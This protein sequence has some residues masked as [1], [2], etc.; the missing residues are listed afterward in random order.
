MTDTAQNATARVH[1]RVTGRVQGV[2]YRATTQERAQSLGLTGWVSN[3]PDG[4]V[5]LEAQGPK[6]KLDALAAW[7][8]RGPPNAR[9]DAVA[10]TPIALVPDERGFQIRRY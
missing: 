7:C 3:K 4:S 5:E 6:A 1:L 10:V 9:V 8:R 2:F